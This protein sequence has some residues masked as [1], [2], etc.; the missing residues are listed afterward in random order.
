MSSRKIL[1]SGFVVFVVGLLFLGKESEA[2]VEEQRR[3]LPPAAECA[4]D[5]EGEWL[6]LTYNEWFHD[7]YQVRLRVKRVSKGSSELE[8]DML[9]R[10]WYG[11]AS[12]QKP[13]GCSQP[14]AHER[15]VF[16]TAKG[17][18][19]D[20]E[21]RFDAQ[22]WKYAP[23]TCFRD[24][25]YNL[26]HYSGRIDPKLHEFQSVNNDGG[27]AVNEPSVFRRIKCQ[28]GSA[29]IVEQPGPRPSDVSIELRPPE[30]KPPRRLG[31]SK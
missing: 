31:C 18:F 2:S 15:L 23:D 21:I 7:W 3:R 28:E 8:G 5:L 4:D 17:S 24:G 13:P 11:Q 22:T 16:Q 20:G 26:D 10:F 1:R 12:E 19:R 25:R 27:R 9:V 6:A 30:F 29:A 14:G